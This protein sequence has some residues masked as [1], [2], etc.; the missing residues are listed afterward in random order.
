MASGGRWR[1]DGRTLPAALDLE[2]ATTGDRCHGLGRPA[3]AAWVA[4]FVDGY[5]ERTGRDPVIYTS[6]EFWDA[7]VGTRASDVS[8]PLWLFDHAGSPG[9][10]P[11]G[12]TRPLL[13]QRG[14]E[15]GLDRNVFLGSE[16]SLRAWAR[17][18]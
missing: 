9:P 16:D 10:L 4:A 5:R 14:V 15:G 8:A 18:G 3:L 6:K 7:C 1:G 11:V 17:M 2:F 13:W 12:W